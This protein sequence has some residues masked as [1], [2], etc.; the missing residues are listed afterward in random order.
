MAIAIPRI[1]KQEVNTIKASQMSSVKKVY[2]NGPKKPVPPKILC[3]TGQS[4]ENLT[5]TQDAVRSALDSDIRWIVAVMESTDGDNPE[6]EWSGT[7]ARTAR[8]RGDT[9]DVSTK[10]VFG[11]L[12]DSPPAHPDTV[13][14]T[15]LYIEEF[16]KQHSMPYIHLS[17]DMQLYK[18]IMQ[19]KWSSQDRW[20]NLVVRPGGM[21]TLMS[22][23]GCIG[24]LMN[25]SG[26]E[27][28][29]AVAFKGVGHMLK[30]K[31]WPKAVRGLRMVVC[32]LL[33]PI[34]ESGKM[35]MDT[36]EEELD[37]ARQS[38]TG[39]LW[40]DCLV[41]PVA[42]IHLF[43][44]AEREGDWLLHMYAMKRMLPYFFAAN[45]MNYARYI[46]WH[47]LEMTTSVPD[48]ILAAFLRG[49]HVCRHQDGVW[50]SVFLDQ[51]G[52]QTY[53]R[54]GKAKGGLVGKSL[55]SDQV[56]EWILSHHLCNTISLLMDSAYDVPADNDKTKKGAHTEESNNRKK[57][58][59]EDRN[60]IREELKKHRNP[61]LSEQEHLTNIMNGRIAPREVNVDNAL[62]IGEQ[63]SQKFTAELPDS[64]HR[65]IKK[66]VVTMERLK[67]K[68]QVGDTSIYDM[69]K[70]YA[71]LLVISQ[72]RDIHLSQLFKHELSPVP[73]A[74][75]N[76]YG[77]MRKG[78]KN[79]LVDNLAV[80]P[81]MLLEPVDL[82]I[83][84]GNEA[85][86]HTSWQRNTTYLGKF[87]NSILEII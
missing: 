71:R 46:S 36:I 45:H 40:V 18:V 8:E 51:F 49:E 2:F 53:I 76:E 12:I 9:F 57:L 29:L 72:S 14:I 82:E 73:S 30:G 77:D 35:T 61:I 21:H 52:E 34:I 87:C 4:F 11:P 84:D 3:N 43:I 50:N 68:V 81:T 17:A 63:M 26:L 48:I 23:I 70:L 24:T 59:A 38:R 41:I 78:N 56:G 25:G 75:F 54:Y 79:T 10:F 27:E 6:P 19:V 37:K 83:T 74:L 44:R 86:Y 22:F 80:F 60:K 7:M 65:P 69:E 62:A 47:I 64:F 28:L 5:K 66:E 58:D 33:E 42:I 31:A 85:I 32:A 20:K 16:M 15:L 67:K 13:L 55:S 39:Q 1:S